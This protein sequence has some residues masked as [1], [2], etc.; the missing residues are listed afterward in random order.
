[1]YQPERLIDLWAAV[2]RLAIKDWRTGHHKPG[3][4][5]AARFLEAAG[6]LVDGRLRYDDE[7]RAVM[8]GTGA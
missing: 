6:L 5:D 8:A 3:H 2:A 1:M 4:P 7:E